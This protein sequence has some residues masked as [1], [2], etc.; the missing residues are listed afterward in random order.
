[1]ARKRELAT[2]FDNKAPFRMVANSDMRP[3]TAI[4]ALMQCAPGVDPDPSRDSLL[5]L[6]DIL[7]DAIERLTPEDQWIFDALFSRRLSLRECARELG[8]PTHRTIQTKRDEILIR[9]RTILI[10]SDEVRSYLCR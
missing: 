7:Q 10:E 1:M 9:L 3:D 2:S 5:P 4:E 6:R 8:H